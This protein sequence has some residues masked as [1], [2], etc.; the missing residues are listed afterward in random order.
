[1]TPGTSGAAAVPA[2]DRFGPRAPLRD[3]ASAR[4]QGLNEIDEWG[5]DTNLIALL[6][7]LIRTR[8][9]ITLDGLEH[10]DGV[11]PALLVVNSGPDPTERFVT[12]HALRRATGRPTR[13]VTTVDR[14]PA[15][16]LFRK[17]GAVLD[18]PAE[19]AG[20]LASGRRVLVPLAPM[21]W[22]RRHHAGPLAPEVVRPAIDAGAEVL[23]VA[24]VGRRLGR[25]WHVRIGRPTARLRGRSPLAVAELAESARLAVQE[26][27]D[28]AYPPR[29]PFR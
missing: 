16:A 3:L 27:L 21:P 6:E 18:H 26:L 1:M 22:W 12:A 29:W 17:V 10:L 25:R 23:P 11:G 9:S 5:L 4:W 24:A 20:L 15:A 2:D 19:L 8:W 13:F 14:E 7:P 28:D